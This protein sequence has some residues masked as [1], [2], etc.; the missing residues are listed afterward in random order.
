MDAL[1]SKWSWTCR[2][3]RSKALLSHNTAFV[4]RAF[5]IFFPGLWR[6]QSTFSPI[7]AALLKTLL[8]DNW[9]SMIYQD[10]KAIW[11]T[12]EKFEQFRTTPN[13][14]QTMADNL[15]FWAD[16]GALSESLS[17]VG[18][19]KLLQAAYDFELLDSFRL[20]WTRCLQKKWSPDELA[21]FY[22]IY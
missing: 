2:G 10:P 16:I 21:L 19:C 4:R 14:V 1:S 15:Q 17:A 12:P 18:W 22:S 20:L 8:G 13:V 11:F 3:L 5:G 6:G 7:R 9:Y